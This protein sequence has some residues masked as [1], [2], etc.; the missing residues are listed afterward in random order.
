MAPQ[1]QLLKLAEEIHSKTY[2]I[3]KHL[4]AC[5]QV[6]P[7]FD[8]GSSIIESEV[9]S[10]EYKDLQAS[11]NEAANDLILLINGPKT[12]LRTF[13]TTHYELAAYQIAI[14]F[15]F[16]QN[17]PLQGET[18]IAR[19][20]EIVGMDAE[21]TGRVLRLLATQRVFKEVEE[22]KFAHTAA[23]IALATDSEVNSAAGMQYIT[24]G[25]ETNFEPS[26]IQK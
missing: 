14:E 26:L 16:F 6:E 20:A 4:K 3:V 10:K 17:V 11:V 2:K 25:A 24:P 15:R 23:S 1:S 18:G 13:L 9:E 7:T 19:L 12:F 22:D 21:R 8:A 5:G